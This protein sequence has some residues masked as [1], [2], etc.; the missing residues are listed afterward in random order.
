MQGNSRANSES[1]A[2]LLLQLGSG[3]CPE[4][5]FRLKSLSSD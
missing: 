1:L 3:K 2:S 4:D 5:Q